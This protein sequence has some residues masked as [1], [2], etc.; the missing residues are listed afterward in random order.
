MSYADFMALSPSERWHIRQ[1]ASDEERASMDF[2]AGRQTPGEGQAGGLDATAQAQAKADVETR[3]SRGVSH[4]SDS[5]R[6]RHY[7]ATA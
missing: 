5:G 1:N 2:M 6:V 7:N 3:I 4:A